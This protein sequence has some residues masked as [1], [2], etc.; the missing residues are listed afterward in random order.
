MK[1]T[2]RLTLA[3]APEPLNFSA[4]SISLNK[5]RS[6]QSEHSN[7]SAILTWFAATYSQIAAKG[8]LDGLL[9]L[10]RL[11]II[12]VVAWQR[13]KLKE[14]VLDFGWQRAPLL[15]EIDVVALLAEIQP[16]CCPYRQLVSV[17]LLQ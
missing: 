2:E 3:T 17:P 15:L 6:Q 16:F 9:R 14:T 8:A 11:V 1:G 4:L 7:D 13:L 10:A 5:H 12:I